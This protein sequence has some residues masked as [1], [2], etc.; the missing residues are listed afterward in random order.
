MQ[1]VRKSL[2]IDLETYS[3]IDLGK[4]GIYKYVESPEF[5]ILLFGYSIDG[6]DVRVVDLAEGES[7]PADIINA[8]EDEIIL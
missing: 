3:S 6:G 2:T 1:T 8:L 5:E 4:S 7:I